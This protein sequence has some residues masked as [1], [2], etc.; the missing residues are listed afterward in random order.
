MVRK[1][2]GHQ[3]VLLLSVHWDG[4]VVVQFKNLPVDMKQ[5][6][7]LSTLPDIIAKDLSYCVNK[8]SIIPG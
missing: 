4:T 8:N 1:T 2:T 5:T 7:C 3:F 6:S